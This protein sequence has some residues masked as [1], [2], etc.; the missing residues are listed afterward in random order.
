[1]ITPADAAKAHTATAR[2]HSKRDMTGFQIA[3]GRCESPIEQAFCLALFQLPGVLSGVGEFEYPMLAGLLEVPAPLISVFAQQPIGSYRADFLLV[4]T[5]QR[6]AEPAFVIVECDGLEYHS[7]REQ[8]H[9]DEQR[10]KAL[11]Q[12]GFKV[13]RFAG[14]TLFGDPESVVAITLSQFTQHGW[15]PSAAQHFVSNS[16]LRAALSELRSKAA[17]S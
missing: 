4:G 7:T 2:S 11:Q 10:Q 16:R 1:M 8:L 6:S 14:K 5:S 9:R 15:P 3:F 12:S 13:I 17:T